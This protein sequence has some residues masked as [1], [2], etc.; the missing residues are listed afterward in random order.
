MLLLKPCCEFRRKLYKSLLT[1]LFFLRLMKKNYV[2][3]IFF[4]IMCNI[5]K[6]V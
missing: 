2:V 4:S 5:A 1:L 3:V 6:L